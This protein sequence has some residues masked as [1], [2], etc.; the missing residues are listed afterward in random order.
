[1]AEFQLSY[2]AEDINQKLGKVDKL[3]GTVEI[4]SGVPTKENTV[5]TID[6]TAEEVNMYTAPE[7]DEKIAEL[8]DSLQDKITENTNAISELNGNF[9]TLNNKVKYSDYSCYV[10]ELDTYKSLGISAN[11]GY[12]GT[13]HLIIASGHNAAGINS[14]SEIGMIWCGHDGNNFQYNPIFC[15]AL[16]N[17][18]TTNSQLIFDC[19][20]DGTLKVKCKY[21]YIRVRVLSNR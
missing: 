11:G 17:T 6:P 3:G 21:Y 20:E 10:Y 15:N 14:F 16:G 12:G 13:C 19:D 7:V 1:M 4:T 18:T 9:E 5:L 2:T 8:D